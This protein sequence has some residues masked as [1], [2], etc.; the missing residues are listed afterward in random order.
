MNHFIAVE[1]GEHS[2]DPYLVIHCG[3]RNL[4]KAVFDHY[5]A[6][7][8]QTRDCRL[9][10]LRFERDCAIRQAAEDGEYGRIEALKAG[11]QA[12]VERLS[13]DD[14]C[15]LEG[16]DMADYLHDMDMLREWSRLN[17]KVIAE[18][19]TSALGVE[20]HGPGVSSVHNYVDV[21]HHVI[22]KGAISAQEGEFG[23]IPMNMRDGSLIVVGKGNADYLCSAPHGAG[24][25]MS[26]AQ[27]KRELD[28]KRYEDEMAD[29]YTTSVKA[30][31]LD[32]A[33]DAYKAMEDIL[34]AI[35]PTVSVLERTVPVYNFKAS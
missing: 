16:R 28:L 19:I 30:T 15:Y 17:H 20:V 34:P 33:P 4:G 14:L 26:R 13:N 18:E 10:T 21:E 3:T 8:I 31:T 1:V 11:Y 24:R 2:N 35:E 6:L 9:R 23:I 25:I 32:E 27:A 7:A 12:E 5:Q 29:V 22:R